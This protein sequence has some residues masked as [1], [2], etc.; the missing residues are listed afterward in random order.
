MKNKLICLIL[1]L[2]MIATCFVGCA[3]KDEDEAI[4][5]INKAASQEAATLVMYLM[6]E[7]EVSAKQEKAIEAAVNELTKSKFKTQLDLRF[8]TPDEY[9]QALE[10]AFADRKA[11][12]AAGKITATNKKD[13]NTQDEM[14]EDEWGVSQIK[15]PGVSDYQVDI[16]YLGGYNKYSEYMEMEILQKLDDEISTG[17]SK[18]SSYISTP[19]LT[20]MK[21]ANDGTYALP[22]NTAIGEYTYLL[23][24][25]DAL[26]DLDYDT[27]EGLKSFTGLT[28]DAVKD[29]LADI[30]T[31][32]LD[33]ADVTESYTHALY[34]N[35][36]QDTL[37]STGIYYW[38]VDENGNLSN[39]FSALASDVNGKYMNMT[40][41]LNTKF[42][43]HLK[44][45]KYY[46]EAYDY[47]SPTAAT[48]FANGKV[49]VA[50]ITGGAEIPSEYADKYEAIVIGQPTLN[51]MD[52][53]ENM[54]AVSY[55]TASTAR[56]MEIITYLNTD[57]AFRNLIQYG[58]ENEDYR[59]VDSEYTDAEGNPYKVVKP[60]KNNDGSYDYVMDVNKTGN[61]LIAYNVEGENPGLKEFIKKQNTEAQISLTM[62]YRVD[63]EGFNVDADALASLFDLS[64]AVLFALRSC[65]YDNFDA[66]VEQLRT[67]L[68]SEECVSALLADV[69]PEKDGDKCGLNY[70]YTDWAIYNGFYTR[71]EIAE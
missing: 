2:M 65:T 28:S 13:E 35:L 39:N 51:T 25:R 57:E 14:Y 4:D 23:V 20:Y 3:A 46:D 45:V 63:Y 61:T 67:Q 58:I 55:Y 34:S 1:A 40:N 24:N 6:S 32:Q 70:S 10:K 8:Y 33:N 9:Y 31:Y 44:T 27:T 68:E 15:Y 29:F 11:A 48:A 52:L 21:S 30:K 47:S 66:T 50:C 17:S 37:A 42:V 16:F 41:V 36:S 7:E 64:T 43:E 59:L 69:A 53:Y 54:F 38:G 22:T 18:L 62:G 49:A 12:E 26:A 56:S 5:D 19:F 71:P 60:I